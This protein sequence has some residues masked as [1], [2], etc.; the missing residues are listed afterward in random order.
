MDRA[1]NFRLLWELNDLVIFWSRNCT[2]FNSY[3]IH[4]VLINYPSLSLS[5]LPSQLGLSLEGWS[6][7]HLWWYILCLIEY[8]L[9]VWKSSLFY[10]EKSIKYLD[11]ASIRKSSDNV[12]FEKKQLVIL[13]IPF[14]AR[15]QYILL[16]IRISK[17]LEVPL[18]ARKAEYRMRRGGRW[19]IGSKGVKHATCEFCQIPNMVLVRF[20][21]PAALALLGFYPFFTVGARSLGFGDVYVYVSCYLYYILLLYFT[22]KFR[23]YC[24]ISITM[25]LSSLWHVCLKF[26]QMV[27]SRYYHLSHRCLLFFFFF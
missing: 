6:F 22:S 19:G 17:N 10:A 13:A 26:I 21:I 27:T 23:L 18:P 9:G 24:P 7:K 4:I 8:G 16:K 20:P 14:S 15:C 1:S 3:N 11:F 12:Y 2:S 5:Y 25:N